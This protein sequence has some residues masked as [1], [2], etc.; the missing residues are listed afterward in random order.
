MS[1]SQSGVPSAL[2]GNAVNLSLHREI[3]GSHLLDWDRLELEHGSVGGKIWD[4]GLFSE[5]FSL[6][7]FPKP[8][9]FPGAREGLPVSPFCEWKGRRMVKKEE[10]SCALPADN[11]KQ[12]LCNSA[13]A[14][15]V[16]S[17]L[18][19]R[20]IRE[21]STFTSQQAFAHAS[22]FPELLEEI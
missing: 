1:L 10:G 7:A 19:E 6:C 14:A 5:G 22:E 4:C 16:T 11:P 3:W 15:L 21:Q 2:E 8:Q 20:L 18:K 13:L 9:A 12:R 17:Y